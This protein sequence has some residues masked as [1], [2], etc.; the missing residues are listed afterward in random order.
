[1]I[2]VSD[3]GVGNISTDTDQRRIIA[4]GS[5]KVHGRLPG[6]DRI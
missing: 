6:G 2:E 4:Y 1:M 5:Q 3:V